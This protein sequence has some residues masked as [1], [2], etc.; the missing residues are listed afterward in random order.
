M[1]INGI[2]SS[3]LVTL[4]STDQIASELGGDTNAQVAAM[5][6]VHSKE[7][8]QQLRQ[9]RGAEEEHLRESEDREVAEMRDEAREI[10][11]AARARAVGG[12][13]EG[14]MTIG[15]GYFEVA[16]GTQ[17]DEASAKVLS[18]YGKG[19]E[20]AGKAGKGAYDLDAAEDDHAAAMARVEAQKA[21]NRAGA[22]E[23]RLDDLKDD[24]AEARELR[25][26]AIDFVKDAT[27]GQADVHRA[28]LFQRV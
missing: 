15:A 14:I 3:V 23:R 16:S 18:G 11:E 25:Q 2:Q 1:S 5:L 17:S 6:V 4:N 13:F 20:G 28:A 26:K 12:I 8:S 27:Q 21:K 9:A 22:S 19:V 7:R 10:R 24:L